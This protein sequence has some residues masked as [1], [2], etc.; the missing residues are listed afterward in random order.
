[1]IMKMPLQKSKFFLKLISA[2]TLFFFSTGLLGS[3][4]AQAD[5][6]VPGMDDKSQMSGGVMTP[7]E[8]MKFTG[9]WEIADLDIS[10]EN[11]SLED[12]KKILPDEIV[13][14]IGEF[15]TFLLIALFSFGKNSKMMTD[16][17]P[18]GSKTQ[19]TFFGDSERIQRQ[20]FYDASGKLVSGWEIYESGVYKWK[21]TPSTGIL[22]DNGFETYYEDVASGEMQGD[23]Q[24]G[25][26]AK[27]VRS[28]KTG[29]SNTY[30]SGTSFQIKQSTN[31]KVEDTENVVTSYT[32]YEYFGDSLQVK[33]EVERDASKNVVSKFERYESGNLKSKTLA[34]EN[35]LTM[36]YE[37]RGD[38]VETNQGSVVV[39]RL[40]AEA[41]AEGIVVSRYEYDPT[42]NMLSCFKTYDEKTGKPTGQTFYTYWDNKG[43]VKTRERF[44]EDGLLTHRDTR[45]SNGRIESE[46]RQ[47]TNQTAYFTDEYISYSNGKVYGNLARVVYAAGED[48]FEYDFM[49]KLSERSTYVNGVLT[50]VSHYDGTGQVVSTEFPLSAIP[51]AAA[52]QDYD[53]TYSY[54]SS[55]KPMGTVTYRYVVSYH[56]G[57]DKL[58]KVERY[59]NGV[60]IS[61]NEYAADGSIESL[62]AVAQNTLYQFAVVQA[63]VASVQ[64][65]KIVF[66]KGEVTLDIAKTQTDDGTRL[67]I[68][69]E[70]MR[71]IKSVYSTGSWIETQYQHDDE[72]KSKLKESLFDENGLL[73][74]GLAYSGNDN[75]ISGMITAD[76]RTLDCSTY[77]C[78]QYDAGIQDVT[79]LEEI[80]GASVAMIDVD[81][82]AAVT[83]HAQRVG[84]ILKSLVGPD[85]QT[86][87]FMTSGMYIPG[88][89][90]DVADIIHSV[91]DQGFKVINLSIGFYINQLALL[92]AQ[93]GRSLAEDILPDFMAGLQ[94]AVD[95]ALSKNAVVVV[96]GGNMSATV[97]DPATD[98]RLNPTGD[99]SI[100]TNLKG[101]VSVGASDALGRHLDLFGHGNALSL[102]A[103]GSQVLPNTKSNGTSFAT[104]IV[105]AVISKLLGYLFSVRGADVDANLVIDAIKSSAEDLGLEGHDSMFGWGKI[106]VSGAFAS[107]LKMIR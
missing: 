79:E 57:T 99:L 96:A 63:D 105:S 23:Y 48:Y 83:S 60:L 15:L 81:P 67:V 101:V 76:G 95:Y 80:A 16:H 43:S 33:S 73:V 5:G 53:V 36:L 41:N 52:P 14:L 24:L 74:R 3:S 26:I 21:K 28:D 40:V 86:R 34:G 31:F 32:D 93:L 94:S 19:T 90:N 49:N 72:R 100:L 29:Y 62:N 56:S 75:L 37:D 30:V 42:T 45:Y 84:T 11:F 46:Y 82:N 102:T 6:L 98:T 8:L 13:A 107:L 54:A 50:Q 7:D 104:P 91:V 39:P 9:D 65:K 4:A 92:A 64:L 68:Y 22:T 88:Q 58:K 12:L 2:L 85:T 55:S 87:T 20:E 71:S 35:N 89:R 77:D 38:V 17:A 51:S 103:N 18:D 66:S 61:V 97:I 27:V 1:M 59:E 78:L 47:A 69:D 106:D 70:W 44:D 25:R 10:K